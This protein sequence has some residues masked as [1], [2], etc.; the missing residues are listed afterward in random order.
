MDAVWDL[1]RVLFEPTAV[2]ERVR[3]RPRIIAPLATILV[4]FLIIQILMM[5]YTRV[6]A[7]AAMQQAM[8]QRGVPADQM[9]PF[10][11]AYLVIGVIF[12]L[13]IL[14]LILIVGTTVLWISASL[15]AGEGRFATLFSV[16]IY[17]SILFV[18]Q[19]I[20]WMAI[21]KMRGTGAITSPDDLQPAIGLDLLL[22]EAKGFL[23]GLLKGVN[24]FAIYGYW[25]TAIGVSVTHRT[26]RGTGVTV[27]F[28]TFVVML[29]LFAGLYAIRPGH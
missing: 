26:S 28:L 21:V 14:L 18:I 10:S 9:P 6:V 29:M 5:P 13:V 11:P 8:Q 17:T 19:Q 20:V 2:F 16:T 7:E 27:A 23:A 3:E 4:L 22:P 15:F 25:L 24:P 1:V 12:G